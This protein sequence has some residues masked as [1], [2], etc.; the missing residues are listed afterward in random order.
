MN[1]ITRTSKEKVHT[2]PEGDLREHLESRDCWCKPRPD[3]DDPTVWVHN[4]MDR[5]EEYE[6]GRKLS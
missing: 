6:Q 4:S 3:D 5:R 2:M 1:D